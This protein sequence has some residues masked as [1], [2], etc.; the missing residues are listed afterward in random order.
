MTDEALFTS[1]NDLDIPDLQLE[2]CA[3]Y[4]VLP[5]IQWGSIARYRAMS[6]TWGFYVDDVV[7]EPVWSNPEGPL[8]STPYA[9]IEPNFSITIDT[10]AALAIWQ[11]YRKRWLARFWQTRGI[12]T[13]VDLS[14][15]PRWGEVNLLGVPKGW[16][17]FATR[18][19]TREPDDL[20]VQQYERA[21]EIASGSGKFLF[22][23]YGGGN[24]L[25]SRHPKLDK[26]LWSCDLED[27][28]DGYQWSS[29]Q[30]G[31]AL[32]DI[33]QTIRIEPERE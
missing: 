19:Y 9:I 27:E 30:I 4:L 7:I 17:S 10:P 6:G 13:I 26:V 29:W 16:W 15:H 14:V 33:G 21:R 32:H 18:G 12:K 31:K 24:E 20:L 22:L 3:D 5:Y 2:M 28:I 23:V 8:K 1:T 11:V 25:K